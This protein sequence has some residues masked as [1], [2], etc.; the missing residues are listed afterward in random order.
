MLAP[1]RLAGPLLCLA[2]ATIAVPAS[3]QQDGDE[4]LDTI[5]EWRAANRPD[6]V[7]S[8]AAPAI[9]TARAEGDVAG[10]VDL[11]LVRGATRA[12]FGRARDAEPD[13]REG[14]DLA[15]ARGDTLRRLQFT[16]WLGVALGLQ[17]RGS[18]SAALYHE[19]EDLARAAGDSLHLGW[20]WVGIAYEHYLQ[21]RP[22]DAGAAYA[23]AAG[24]LQRHGE[25]QGA[26]WAWNGR[27]LALRQAGRFRDARTAFANVLALAEANGDRVNEALALDQ[28]GRLDLMLGDPGRAERLFARSAAIHRAARHTREGLVPSIDLAKARTMQGRYEEAEALLDSVL[29]VCREHGLRDLEFLATGNLVDG[30][31]DRDRPG[32]ATERCRSLLAGGETPSRLAATETRLRLARALAARDSHVAAAEVLEGVLAEGAGA[33]SLD[34]RVTALLGSV[35]QDAGRSAE[36]AR[37]LRS[38]AASARRAGS[39]AELV[40]LLTHLGRAELACGRPDSA[41]AVFGRAIA[42]WE[43]VRVWPADPVWREHRGTVA[44]SLFAHAVAARLAAPGGLAGAWEWAQRHKARTMQERMLGPGG[45]AASEPAPDLTAFRRQVL[46][47]G[48]VFLD[49]VEGDRL[50]VVFCVTRD[51]AFAAPIPGRRRIAPRLRRLGNVVTSPAL[52]EAGPAARLAAAAVEDWPAAA[53]RLAESARTVWWCPDGSWHRLPAALLGW[54]GALTRVP[55]AGVLARLKESSG[56]DDAATVLAVGGPGPDGEVL[57]PGAARELSWLRAKLHGVVTP[58]VPPDALDPL[59]GEADVLHLA[60]HTALDSRQPWQTGVTLGTGPDRVLR[61]ADVAGLELRAR[62]A[63]L[64]GCTTA[65]SRV[66]GGEGLIGLAGAFLAARTPA[67]LATLWPVDDAAAFRVTT[68]FYEGLADGLTAAAAL[69]RARRD[70]LADPAFAAPRHWA[71]FVLVGDGDVTVPVRRRAA[72]WPWALVLAG[73]A[74]LVAV[75]AKR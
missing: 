41:L 19:L 29:A 33:V 73:L 32:A 51:T 54:R 65:G 47:P 72:R 5:L 60:A 30:W 28:L 48:E 46:G 7:D 34:L 36:A 22:D 26:V 53:R 25:T 64:A 2:V 24:M 10:L 50:G 37:R 69:D 38:A 45:E 15:T 16:R 11:L 35:L 23:R 44:G 12:G 8:L 68:A 63:V 42:G 75:R 59:W 20:S 43:R 56:T 18:E 67:V 4:L 57:M 14:R 31:L 55:A 40:V 39:T 1:R 62:L 3:A 27:G 70:C 17:G 21:G 52:V 74:V 71:A 58:D 66:V 49:V 9:A 13:L 61:A 6:V